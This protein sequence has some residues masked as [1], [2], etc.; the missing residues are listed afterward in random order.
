MIFKNGLEDV[1]KEN[2]DHT[3]GYDI[4]DE[5]R[6]TRGDVAFAKILSDT[7]KGKEI[8]T[9]EDFLAEVKKAWE[10]L[11]GVEFS[12]DRD[13]SKE[14]N[15]EYPEIG[16]SK[17]I[18][19]SDPWEEGSSWGWIQL[20]NWIGDEPKALDFIAKTYNLQ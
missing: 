13:M 20:T 11:T 14:P 1:I 18:K 8:N 16:F 3:G 9:R 4:P 15:N 7:I 10:R 19:E 17:E 6:S 2:R 12:L 5:M